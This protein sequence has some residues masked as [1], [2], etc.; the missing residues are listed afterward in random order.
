MVLACSAQLD[1]NSLRLSDDFAKTGAK[2]LS[3]DDA[4]AA[5]SDLVK[6]DAELYF[7]EAGAPLAMDDEKIFHDIRHKDQPDGSS[8]YN[9]NGKIYNVPLI[10]Y[11]DSHRL[12][13][14]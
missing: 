6:T 5:E 12:S 1:R 2:I 3:S 14:A 7:V 13:P 10:Y 11:S 4:P 9:N 8:H